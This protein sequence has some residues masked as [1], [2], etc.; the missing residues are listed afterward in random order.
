VFQAKKLAWE[1]YIMSPTCKDPAS[2]NLL[3]M[4]ENV[5]K[6][7]K[8]SVNNNRKFLQKKSA[9]KNDLNDLF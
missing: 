1:H 2:K 7:Q 6:T 3:E 9:S 8:F 4:L 5:T